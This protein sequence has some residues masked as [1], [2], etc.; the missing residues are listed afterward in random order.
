MRGLARKKGY[1]LSDHGIKPA[2]HQ[3]N[4]DGWKG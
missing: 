4:G 1:S 3:K 2:D